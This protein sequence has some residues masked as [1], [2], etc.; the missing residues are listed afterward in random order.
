MNLARRQGFKTQEELASSAGIKQSYLSLIGSGKRPLTNTVACD[1]APIL[2]VE[3]EPLLSVAKQFGAEGSSLPVT[4]FTAQITKENEIDGLIGTPSRA[5]LRQDI[6]SIFGATGSSEVR[7][8]G[9]AEPCWI[10]NFD[11]DR[12]DNHTYDAVASYGT[13]VLGT[14]VEFISDTLTIQ[15][16]QTVLLS[17]E[18]EFLMPSWLLV[19]VHPPASLAK[20]YLLTSGGPIIDPVT[21][22]GPLKIL[23]SNPNVEPVE[24]SRRQP[25]ASLRFTLL[26]PGN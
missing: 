24:I 9:S 26:M 19:D 7:L 15:P 16:S 13:D 11:I 3:V 14:R 21:F 1:L 12:L 5:L 8:F 2:K 10:K 17:T 22:E 25:I 6:E 23:V 20:K 4:F 18:E